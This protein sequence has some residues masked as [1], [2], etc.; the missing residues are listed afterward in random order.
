MSTP[1]AT[2]NL[3]ARLDDLDAPALRR[4]LVE[5][6]TRRKLGLPY[7]FRAVALVTPR[8]IEQTCNE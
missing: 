4:L 6:L 2:N 8:M 3:L 7:H 1:V 5:H